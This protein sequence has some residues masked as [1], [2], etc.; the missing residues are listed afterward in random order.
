MASR[1]DSRALLEATTR[2][3]VHSYLKK[4][5]AQHAV[6]PKLGKFA[7]WCQLLDGYRLWM[8][9][10][11]VDLINKLGILSH[12]HDPKERLEEAEVHGFRNA[13][14][15][16]DHFLTDDVRVPEEIR[17]QLKRDLSAILAPSMTLE[18]LNLDPAKAGNAE[19]IAA[20]LEMRNSSQEALQKVKGSRLRV[21]EVS[22]NFFKKRLNQASPNPDLGPYARRTWRDDPFGNLTEDEKREAAKKA[23]AELLNNNETQ[24]VGSEEFRKSSMESVGPEN[25]IDASIVRSVSGGSCDLNR[26]YILG[27]PMMQL[28]PEQQIHLVSI[29]EEDKRAR[30]ARKERENMFGCATPI[31]NRR[32]TGGADNSESD[33]SLSPLTEEESKDM[34]RSKEENS[35]DN[36]R[37]ERLD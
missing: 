31:W 9:R 34:S 7:S 18:D 6:P 13:W 30:K 28:V 27:A 1:G 32:N 33:D 5:R 37:E 10:K 29:A 35:F 21:A 8:H 20:Y 36:L 2:Q 26:T 4:R 22:Q 19:R 3:K 14:Q 12:K 17:L 16:F 11:D 15:E 23:S 25:S 24:L